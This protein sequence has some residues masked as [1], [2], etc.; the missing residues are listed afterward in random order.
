MLGVPIGQPEFVKDEVDK[1]TGHSV[2]DG[3]LVAPHVWFNEGQFQPGLFACVLRAI[4]GTP[5][6]PD[7]AQM[8]AT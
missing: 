3:S 4:V 1:G 2:K 7:E 6:T 8:L 5:L